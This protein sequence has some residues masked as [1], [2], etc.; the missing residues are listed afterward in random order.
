MRSYLVVSQEVRG[1]DKLLPCYYRNLVKF[2]KIKHTMEFGNINSKLNFM[3]ME[4]FTKLNHML[5]TVS[6]T[7][8][9]WLHEECKT[10]L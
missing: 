5:H 6:E 10:R 4:F 7:D 2:D 9:G 8:T 3:K 1:K